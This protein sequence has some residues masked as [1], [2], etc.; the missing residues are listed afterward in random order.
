MLAFAC[1]RALSPSFTDRPLCWRKLF[2]WNHSRETKSLENKQPPPRPHTLPPFLPSF[3]LHPPLLLFSLNTTFYPTPFPNLIVSPC[4]PLASQLAFHLMVR[5]FP[6][7]SS[8]PCFSL[9]FLCFACQR[10]LRV[11]QV[12]LINHPY[13]SLPHA[14]PL[15]KETYVA[16]IRRAIGEV[17]SIIP[18]FRPLSTSSLSPFSPSTTSSA[19]LTRVPTFI[20]VS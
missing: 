5:S 2:R 8:P 9:R 3:H 11:Q 4:R 12:K 14:D 17:S 10:P 18:F 6:F 16:L 1:P 13:T 19:F 7:E 15:Q 20:T